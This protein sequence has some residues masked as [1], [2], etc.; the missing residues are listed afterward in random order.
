MEWRLLPLDGYGSR[1]TKEFFD[2][3]DDH[4]IIPFCLPP[5]I[6][7]T[8]GCGG[9]WVAQACEKFGLVWNPEEAALAAI[10]GHLSPIHLSPQSSRFA[11]VN[12]LGTDFCEFHHTSMWH[13]LRRRRMK[14]F[15]GVTWKVV[16]DESK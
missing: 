5:H 2:F 8:G 14:L 6:I 9:F 3:C 7:R 10:G 13:D 4:Y 15:I 1:C 11:D 16:A 12:V